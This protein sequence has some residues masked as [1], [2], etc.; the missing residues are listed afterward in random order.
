MGRGLGTEL[1]LR[2]RVCDWCTAACGGRGLVAAVWR[3]AG[4]EADTAS[5]SS[6]MMLQV[7]ALSEEDDSAFTTEWELAVARKKVGV[8]KQ[9]ASRSF[10]VIL[11]ACFMQFSCLPN[12]DAKGIMF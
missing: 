12:L 10:P 7:L 4:D 5:L 11:K 3:Q 6:A 9:L 1:T 8:T 2:P